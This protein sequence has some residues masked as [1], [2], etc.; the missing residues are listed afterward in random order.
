M[1]FRSTFITEHKALCFPDWF[2]EKWKEWIN[3][4][5]FEESIEIPRMGLNHTETNIKYCLPISSKCEA[6]CYGVWAELEGDIQ[7]VI[8]ECAVKP[9]W[10]DDDSLGL[11]FLHECGGITK[12]QIYRNEI[13]YGEPTEWDEHDVIYHNNFS[14]CGCS[15]LKESKNKINETLDEMQQ[16][17]NNILSQTSDLQIA[18]HEQLNKRLNILENLIINLFKKGV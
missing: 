4:N 10:D 9:Y 14:C 18:R 5:S 3:F 8:N 15:D 17:M 13:L 16:K 11:I 12:L 6:K 2:Y 1:G 7:K